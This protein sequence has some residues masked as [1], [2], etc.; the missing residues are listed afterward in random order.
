MLEH[1]IEEIISHP[2][3]QFSFLKLYKAGVCLRRTDSIDSETSWRYLTEND[4][5]SFVTEEKSHLDLR[6]IQ[7]KTVI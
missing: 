2:S 3:D 6:Q 4:F 5:V 7:S 1:Q